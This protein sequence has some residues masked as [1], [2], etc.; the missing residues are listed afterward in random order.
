MTAPCRIKTK[1]SAPLFRTIHK[2]SADSKPACDSLLQ[3]V[4][5]IRCQQC[6]RLQDNHK[7]PMLRVPAWHKSLDGVTN[8]VEEYAQV[9]R[10]HQRI[11]LPHWFSWS[12]IE[13]C[14]CLP[15]AG[16]VQRCLALHAANLLASRKPS[17]SGVHLHFLPD[18]CK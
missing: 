15:H 10:H 8:T 18:A 5:G 7:E 3:Q 14:T 11:P 1:D 13:L 12:T 2:V 17:L 16:S 4:F 6:S 9:Y